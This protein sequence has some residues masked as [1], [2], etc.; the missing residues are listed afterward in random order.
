MN[1]VTKAD[2][3]KI[4]DMAANRFLEHPDYEPSVRDRCGVHIYSC[5]SVETATDEVLKNKMP[6]S[7]MLGTIANL[8]IEQADAGLCGKVSAFNKRDY[9]YLPKRRRVQ[10]QE[11][12]Y[13]WLM[14]VKEAYSCDALTADWINNEATELQDNY[15]ALRASRG[16]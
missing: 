10:Y 11:A 2:I 14:N 9:D 5:L 4:L 13:L 3:V 8:I 7:Y 6:Y 15:L 1:F 16:Y 12:R